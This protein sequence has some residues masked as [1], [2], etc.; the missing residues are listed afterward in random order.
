MEQVELVRRYVVSAMTNPL[1]RIR[2]YVSGVDG[3]QDVVERL[4]EDEF[5]K[6]LAKVTEVVMAHMG[7]KTAVS[8]DQAHSAARRAVSRR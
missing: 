1:A 4:R 3:N 8:A 7:N 2:V 5:D 6:L